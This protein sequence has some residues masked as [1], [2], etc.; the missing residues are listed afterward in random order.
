[1]SKFRQFRFTGLLRSNNRVH[2]DGKTIGL[3]DKK[4]SADFN[5]LSVF[6]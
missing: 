5:E 1:M 3:F 4:F 2:V 6:F